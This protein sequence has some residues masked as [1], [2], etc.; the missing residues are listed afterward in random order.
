[1]IFG[2]WRSCGI[3]DDDSLTDGHG[4]VVVNGV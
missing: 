1:M 4:G 3:R 2:C